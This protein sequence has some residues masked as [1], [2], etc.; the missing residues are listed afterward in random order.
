MIITFTENTMPFV[1]ISLAEQSHTM[2]KPVFRDF[3]DQV[4][5]NLQASKRLGIWDIATEVLYFLDSK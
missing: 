5:S 3:C 4:D 1:I 2:R